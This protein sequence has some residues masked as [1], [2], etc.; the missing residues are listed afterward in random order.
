MK[1]V[2]V[3]AC[4]RWWISPIGPYTWCNFPAPSAALLAVCSGEHTFLMRGHED[5][6][7]YAGYGATSVACPDR[8]V[9]EGAERDE[10]RAGK[11]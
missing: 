3:R 10:T 11:G 4:V 2:R 8:R 9:E 7:S 5:H 1:G 6:E